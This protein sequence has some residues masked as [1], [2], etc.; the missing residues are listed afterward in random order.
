MTFLQ[1]YLNNPSP[2][3]FEKE[4]QRLWL[5]YL[6]AFIDEHFV[7]PYG[8]A[9]G[10][11]NPKAEFKVVIEAHADEISW[12]I[13]YISPEGLLYVIRNGGSDQQIA[14]SKRVNIHTEKGP[15]KAVFG[16]PA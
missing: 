4:G 8:S 9:V 15:L 7:D 13:N 3:G 11:I 14:P 16:W 2:T 6:A 1:D 10:V 12:F 5:K